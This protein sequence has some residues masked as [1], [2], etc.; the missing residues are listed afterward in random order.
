M[1]DLINEME[2]LKHIAAV[3]EDGSADERRAMKQAVMARW[4][5]KEQELT[6]FENALG[7]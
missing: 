6:D 1:N 4:I 7:E 3:L 5:E 2:L